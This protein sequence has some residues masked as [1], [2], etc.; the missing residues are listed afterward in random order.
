MQNQ[1]FPQQFTALTRDVRE[2][3]IIEFGLPMT[4]SAP[5]HVMNGDL[6][7]SGYTKEDLSK[8]TLEKMC[9]YIGSQETFGR[10][11]EITLAK[12]HSELNP[13]MG[14]ITSGKIEEVEDVM[15]EETPKKSNYI[16]SIPK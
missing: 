2:H 16:K 6:V 8:I 13:P 5:T 9:E 1:I 4:P 10:A 12:V 11:W 15:K 7:D 3:L 14:T